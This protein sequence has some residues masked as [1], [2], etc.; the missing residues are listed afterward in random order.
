M[1]IL[2]IILEQPKVKAGRATCI[3]WSIVTSYVPSYLVFGKTAGGHI[4]IIL[5]LAPA[6]L[7][8]PPL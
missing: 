7:S 2:G 6:I 5:L 1:Q 8:T 4:H 3:G